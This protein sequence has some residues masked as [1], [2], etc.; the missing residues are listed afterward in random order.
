MKLSK[1]L[2]VVFGLLMGS[3]LLNGCASLRSIPS[4][5]YYIEKHTETFIDGESAGGASV[6]EL[7]VKKDCV[8]YYN[9]NDKDNIL[10]I[11]MDQDK[12]YQINEKEKTIKDI[13]LK[14]KFA[15][16]EKE[17]KVTAK[18]TDKKKKVDTWGEVYQVLLTSSA[19]GVSTDVEYWVSEKVK[20]PQETRL[21]MS[22]YFG[23][24]KII[25]ELKQ[26]PG[27]PIEIIV[28][29]N[30]QGKKIDMVTKT[31][32]IDHK[33]KI[34]NSLFE[35]PSEYKKIDLPLQDKPSALKEKKASPEKEKGNSDKSSPKTD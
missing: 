27:Y 9:S 12:A 13:D 33:K 28:H 15:A 29:L 31:V 5:N 18:K 21:R 30:V 10:I 16:V 11:R 20:L 14:S 7:W 4:Q 17:I 32:K 24:R 25:E 35:I 22:D 19:R 34:D 1:C 23:Q 6:L 2:F 3:L 26:F 8:R